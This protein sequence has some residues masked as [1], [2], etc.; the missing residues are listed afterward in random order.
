MSKG[1][2]PPPDLA[3]LIKILAN[4]HSY[5]KHARGV[6]NES[7]FPEH[8]KHVN[9]FLNRNIVTGVSSLDKDGAEKSYGR[10]IEDVTSKQGLKSYL[11]KF[12]KSSST[13]GFAHSD[14]KQFILYNSAD[15]VMVILND[16]GKDL[17]TIY[18]PRDEAAHWKEKI[19]NGKQFALANG[20]IEP[21][22]ITGA[23]ISELTDTFIKGIA[24]QPS[25]Y[26]H[27]LGVANGELFEKEVNGTTVTVT[28][29]LNEGPK[30]SYISPSQGIS[31]SSLSQSSSSVSATGSSNAT[32]IVDEAVDKAD[33]A[34]KAAI[35]AKLGKLGIVTSVGLT[36]VIAGFIDEA[37][38]AKRESAELFLKSGAIDKDTF[39]KYILLNRKV[40]KMMHVENVA[41]QGWAFIATTPI[42]EA[43][44]ASDFSKFSKAHHLAPEVHKALGMSMFDGKS[45]IGQF[46]DAAFKAIPNKKEGAP[47]ILHTLIDSK[48]GV[49]KAD[50]NLTELKE[51]ISPKDLGGSNLKAIISA[52]ESLPEAAKDKVN[53]T[54]TYSKQFQ[55]TFSNPEAAKDI[56]NTVLNKMSPKIL[57]DMTVAS[58]RKTLKQPNV[59]PLI[60][61]LAESQEK[62]SRLEVKKENIDK[63]LASIKNG[64]STISKF[65]EVVFSVLPSN[66]ESVPKSLHPL[67]DS[68]N[69]VIKAGE[70]LTKRVSN[71]VP[72][73]GPMWGSYSRNIENKKEGVV[74][75]QWDKAK[76]K[77]DYSKQFQ[78]AFTDPA[79]AKYLASQMPKHLM[80]DK[81]TSTF[82]KNAAEV[83]LRQSGLELKK[84]SIKTQLDESKALNHALENKLSKQPEMVKH[85]IVNHLSNQKSAKTVEIDSKKKIQGKPQKKLPSSEEKKET[86][87]QTGKLE[88]TDN[89][90]SYRSLSSAEKSQYLPGQA[91][92]QLGFLPQAG[93]KGQRFAMR[94]VRGE[95]KPLRLYSANAVHAADPNDKRDPAQV[96]LQTHKKIGQMRSQNRNQ[97]P[98]MDV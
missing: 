1:K 18:R 38:G 11:D 88:S 40:E 83:Q 33:N 63:Q 57:L 44:A 24:N 61:D 56:I 39:D 7:G 78:Q 67:I 79:A 9:V 29:S 51:K 8:R 4:G 73:D 6:T 71:S 47:K 65:T 10:I 48:N 55:K 59:N 27:R 77:L 97:E 22:I 72:D 95:D 76:A 46:A 37:H 93:E 36:A 86:N 82:I 34:T 3:G 49:V 31:K 52:R 70:N 69:A 96:S 35:A 12:F 25:K 43:K 19:D 80:P 92:K 42:V 87:K 30:A 16:G 58:A 90:K 50:N 66:K 64:K 68:R 75:A 41:G 28:D 94:D 53:A 23:K 32:K 98:E 14:G 91:W 62:Q 54:V 21:K 89:I 81:N 15:N 74:S 84:I 5:H 13:S 60:R 85:Y 26:N 2:L 20:T 45:T 17:G